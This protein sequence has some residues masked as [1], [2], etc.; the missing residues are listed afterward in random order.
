MRKGSTFLADRAD[1]SDANRA[2]I[3]NHGRFAN[4]PARRNR[5]KG[6]APSTFFYRYRNL[7]ERSC[8]KL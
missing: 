7:I 4:I 2:Q 1:G 8:G 3:E 6:F 5:R